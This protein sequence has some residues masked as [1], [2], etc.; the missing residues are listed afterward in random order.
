MYYLCKPLSGD[1]PVLA[2]KTKFLVPKD[3]KKSVRS[4]PRMACIVYYTL[5]AC[6]LLHPLLRFVYF[7]S[8]TLSPVFI[9]PL[10]IGFTDL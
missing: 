4:R 6:I 2:Q 10:A 5:M 9:L 8:T 3:L 1:G 7:N